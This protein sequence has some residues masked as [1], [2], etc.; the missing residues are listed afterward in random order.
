MSEARHAGLPQ[1]GEK[2]HSTYLFWIVRQLTISAELILR[3]MSPQP[4]QNL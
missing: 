3:Q 2:Q 4:S 1:T